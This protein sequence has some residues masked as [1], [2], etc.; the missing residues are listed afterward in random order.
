[1]VMWETTGETG[2]RVQAF[3]LNCPLSGDLGRAL[4]EAGP[5]WGEPHS[6]LRVKAVP[7][8]CGQETGQ[9]TAGFL[10]HAQLL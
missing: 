9:V 8:D 1:M 3:A 2:R 4:A 10:A 6:D 7:R 5:G